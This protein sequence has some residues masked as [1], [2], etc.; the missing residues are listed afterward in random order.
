MVSKAGDCMAFGAYLI[1][2]KRFEQAREWLDRALKL[3]LA[4]NARVQKDKQSSKQLVEQLD[5]RTLY[6][7]IA[8]TAF[9]VIAVSFNG[10]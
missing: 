8:Y 10:H 4:D 9:M 1:E 6:E 7:H 2:E 5:M 3:A